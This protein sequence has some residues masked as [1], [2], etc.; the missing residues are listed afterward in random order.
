MKQ[1]CPNLNDMLQMSLDIAII[2]INFS[3]GMKQRYTFSVT[4]AGEQLNPILC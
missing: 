2:F 1:V 4:V 3:R